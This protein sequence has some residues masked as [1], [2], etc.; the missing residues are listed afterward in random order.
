MSTEIF[1]HRCL[2]CLVGQDGQFVGDALLYRPRVALCSR[3]VDLGAAVGRARVQIAVATLSG[4]TVL[5]KLFTPI[6]HQA[7]KLV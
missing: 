3:V 2:T 6:V 1:R 5:C 7:A 4:A